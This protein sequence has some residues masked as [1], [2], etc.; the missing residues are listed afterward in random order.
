[1]ELHRVLVQRSWH[2]C[3]SS[4]RLT[5]YDGGWMRDVL[6]DLI[7]GL[8]GSG[9]GLHKKLAQQLQLLLALCSSVTNNQVRLSEALLC[10]I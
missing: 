6:I 3:S 4:G 1:M 2:F 9:S 7:Q 8:N 5:L 10:I